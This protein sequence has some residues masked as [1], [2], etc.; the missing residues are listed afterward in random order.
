MK[1]DT[2]LKGVKRPLPP[3]GAVR[4]A[5]GFLLYVFIFFKMYSLFVL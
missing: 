3:F 2:R 1:Q 4:V 5:C